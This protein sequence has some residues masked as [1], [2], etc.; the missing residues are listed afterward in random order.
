LVVPQNPSKRYD[1]R[2]ND[3][4]PPEFP[5]EQISIVE[6]DGQTSVVPARDSYWG[7]YV[8]DVCWSLFTWDF[9]VNLEHLLHL[10]MST[11]I[12]P[13]GLIGWGGSYGGAAH[14]LIYYD[15]WH[16]APTYRTWEELEDMFELNPLHIP[17]LKKAI[18]Y[19]ARLQQDV[20]MSKLNPQTL[21]LEKDVFSYLPP[22]VLETVITLLPTPD[23]RSLRLASPVFATLGLSERFWASRFYK[24]REFEYLPD[25]FVTPPA[26]WRAFYLSLH[27]WASDNE[28]I[29]NR[30]RVWTVVKEL[31]SVL[32]QMAESDC[33]GLTNEVAVEETKSQT[34]MHSMTARRQ[35]RSF[36][37]A[38]SQERS[39]CFPES[40]QFSSV[41]VSFVKTIDGSF[42][43][44]LSF[45]APDGQT[46]HLGYIHRENMVGV[47][48]G[49]PQCVMGFELAFDVKGIRAIKVIAEDGTR[50][51]PLGDPKKAPWKLLE[52]D[53][54][55]STLHA[56]FDV[57]KYLPFIFHL[58]NM[59]S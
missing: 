29:Q 17:T 33:R 38:T 50:W 35:H 7:F 11:P 22:E 40:V 26:S 21:G 48:L 9:N 10:Y 41:C 13:C 25:V 46:A 15:G 24:G 55:I 1:D 20:F 37:P 30:K 12:G 52:S 56:C 27:V 39:L 34:H 16:W 5:H 18:G 28:G 31:R 2:N 19:T 47:R 45:V 36:R 14:K 6:S 8:H 57:S 43:S 4:Q 49:H 44:G 42:V 59:L 58:S 32:R 3:G 23:V 51:G 54:G 53:D